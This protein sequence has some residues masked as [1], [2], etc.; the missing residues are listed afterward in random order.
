MSGPSDLV[1]ITEAAHMLAEARTLPEIRRVHNLA[2]RAHDYARAARMS[3][4]A[5]NSAAAIRLEA[6]AKAGEL[7]VRMKAT[8]ERARE[9]DNQRYSQAATTSL[10]DIGVTPDESSRWQAVAAVPPDERAAYVAGAQQRDEE[11]TRAGLLR[12]AR[13]LGPLPMTDTHRQKFPRLAEAD[14]RARLAQACNQLGRA[15]AAFRLADFDVGLLSDG[16]IEMVRG[17]VH[18]AGRWRDEWATAVKPR[19]LRIVGV[20][21]GNDA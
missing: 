12:H 5:Q 14:E 16:D 10:A 21:N 4:D 6:E 20:A 3:L 18:D 8:G 17:V 7:L 9:G 15:I 13:S 2:Q 19:H 1:A 11:V